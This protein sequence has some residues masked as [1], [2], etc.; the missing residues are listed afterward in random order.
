MSKSF[1]LM[2]YAVSDV[3]AAVPAAV[4]TAAAV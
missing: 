1:E 4:A 2:L 3:A